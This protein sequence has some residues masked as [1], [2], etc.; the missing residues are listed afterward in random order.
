MKVRTKYLGVQ[1]FQ[2]ARALGGVTMASI[3][4]NQ[5]LQF[6]TVFTKVEDDEAKCDNMLEDEERLLAVVVHSIALP[7]PIQVN[8]LPQPRGQVQGRGELNERLPLPPRPIQRPPR[9][10]SNFEKFCLSTLL[11]FC[12]FAFVLFG[13]YIYTLAVQPGS[14]QFSLFDIWSWP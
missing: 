12:L 8:P 10:R 13:L 6:E 11:L 14:F 2:F 9:L 4:S 5:A 7:P 3:P 1:L